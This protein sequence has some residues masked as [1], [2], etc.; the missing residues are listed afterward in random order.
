MRTA[1]ILAAWLWFIV[2]LEAFTDAGA[3]SF[4]ALNVFCL[5]L[6]I[7]LAW[8]TY[9]ATKPD[10]VS[11]KRGRWAWLS[12][13]I[14]VP[15]PVVLLVTGWGFE[16]R[17]ALSEPYLTEFA[18]S[19]REGCDVIRGNRPRHDYY[20]HN[21]PPRRVGLFLAFDAR[22]SGRNGQEVTILTTRSFT[23][24]CGLAYCPEGPPV[25]SGPTDDS[26]GSYDHLR[27]PWHSCAV[28]P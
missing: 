14:A 22:K 19:V 27:G 28:Y 5:G 11:A 10:L 16:L 21:D 18:E 20:Y 6:F 25:P 8:V 13:L 2:A 4:F 9:S 17:F 15:L 1:I 7:L 24:Y 3:K 23:H 26:A 12:V